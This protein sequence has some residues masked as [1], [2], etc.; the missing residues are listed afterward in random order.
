[1]AA[2]PGLCFKP[3]QS[4]LPQFFGFS[5]TIEIS[6]E[7]SALSYS[8]L[9]QDRREAPMPR[10]LTNYSIKLLAALLM[11]IDHIGVVLLPQLAILRVIG[12][13]SFPLFA[14]LL[15]QG[16]RHTTRFR[17]YALRLLGFG[18]LS[19]PI[20]M[21]TF[22][23]QRPNILFVLLVGLL[24]L[25]LARTFPRWQLF[26]WLGSGAL[27]AA[28]DLEYG[29]YGI[30]VIALISWFDS[31]WIWWISW[32]LLHLLIWLV[33]PNLGQSQAPAIAAPLLFSLATQERGAKARW[34]Y[35]FY[36]V[37]L[38]ILWLIETAIAVAE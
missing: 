23:V 28:V 8:R 31:T 17:R 1:M 9:D 18:L 32:L 24:C 34:F 20:Y 4:G 3:A 21:L 26:I 38:L 13:F 6:A 12:R 37:H 19:Q 11:L 22:R 5:L 36:P 33:S 25:R 30:A 35:W 15:V 27:A 16:E 7:V 10:S 29:S 2:A 14:W